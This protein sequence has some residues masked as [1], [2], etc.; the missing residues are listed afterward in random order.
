MKCKIGSETV[1]VVNLRTYRTR[2][3]LSNLKMWSGV[4]GKIKGSNENYTLLV[5][6]IIGSEKAQIKRKISTIAESERRD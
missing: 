6:V 2:N 3:Q 4:S 1:I 5:L